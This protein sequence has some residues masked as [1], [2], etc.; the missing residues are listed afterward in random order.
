MLANKRIDAAHKA[1][2]T[3]RM[4]LLSKINLEEVKEL[5]HSIIA[6]QF[7]IDDDFSRDGIIAR[8]VDKTT[9]ESFC[10]FGDRNSASKAL[11]LT[12]IDNKSMPLDSQAASIFE[13]YNLDIHPSELAEFII[14]HDHGKQSFELYQKLAGLKKQ[15]RYLTGFNWDCKWVKSHIINEPGKFHEETDLPF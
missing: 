1:V 5:A 3:F 15:F 14:N 9:W 12:W 13:Q 6:L 11:I 4:N 7:E 2:K 10:R 8:E